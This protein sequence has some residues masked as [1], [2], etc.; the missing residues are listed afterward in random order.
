MTEHNPLTEYLEKEASTMSEQQWHDGARFFIGLREPQG[1]EK[2]AATRSSA[3]MTADLRR[4]AQ[5]RLLEHAG[6]Q[7]PGKNKNADIIK[8]ASLKWLGKAVM[9]G[10]RDAAAAGKSSG[11]RI[12]DIVGKPSLGERIGEKYR[13]IK[14]GIGDVRMKIRDA[15][16]RHIYSRIPFVG[17]SRETKLRWLAERHD[18]DYASRKGIEAMLKGFDNLKAAK[19]QKA[20]GDARRVMRGKGLTGKLDRLDASGLLPGGKGV[21][22]TLKAKYLAMKAG[23]A[24]KMDAARKKR[25]LHGA[26]IGGGALAGGAALGAAFR[27]GKKKSQENWS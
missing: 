16:R 14:G 18:T 27:G 20:L 4:R 17:P 11:K 6:P 23:R 13:D 8:E 1:Q 10:G 25:I 3:Q 2:T 24:G 22:E 21:E 7:A 12:K 19:G 26:A 9:Q 5:A 15:E